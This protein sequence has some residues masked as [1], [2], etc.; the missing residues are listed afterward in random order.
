MCLQWSLASDPK[1]EGGLRLK[2]VG[3]WNK[4]S[5]LMH[6]WNLFVKAGSDWVAWVM[7]VHEYLLRKRDFRT[8]NIPQEAT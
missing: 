2:R 4:A 1:K 8:I 5:A 7:G 6:I 3:N